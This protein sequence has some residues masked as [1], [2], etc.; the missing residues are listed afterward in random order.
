MCLLCAQIGGDRR[1][2][3]L[4]TVYILLLLQRSDKLYP[5]NAC[6]QLPP[7]WGSPTLLVIR[8]RLQWATKKYGENENRNTAKGE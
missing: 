7:I 2:A 3:S 1:N 5:Y 6:V 4:R 8:L